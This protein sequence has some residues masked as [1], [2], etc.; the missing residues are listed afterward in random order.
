MRRSSR[1]PA[2]SSKEAEDDDDDKS[3]ALLV[4]SCLRQWIQNRKCDSFSE[5]AREME[6]IFLDEKTMT[7]TWRLPFTPQAFM[8]VQ[9]MPNG[10]LE[11]MER[12]VVTETAGVLA[13]WERMKHRAREN[14][15]PMPKVGLPPSLPPSLRAPGPDIHLLYAY[16]HALSRLP[17]RP[18]GFLHIS[19]PA[20]ERE[21]E[22][23]A[24]HAIASSD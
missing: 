17:R 12:R 23:W 13:E 10:Y 22:Y 21:R 3:G 15:K 16:M 7:T 14:G 24:L 20:R 5:N 9:C 8:E 19:Q 11:A 4:K 2:W 18:S 6:D 1:A